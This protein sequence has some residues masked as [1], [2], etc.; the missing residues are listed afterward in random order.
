MATVE[1]SFGIPLLRTGRVVSPNDRYE[2]SEKR[3]LSRAPQLMNFVS[4]SGAAEFVSHRRMRGSPLRKD[5]AY[6]SRNAGFLGPLR[7]APAQASRKK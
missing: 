4:L 2:Q 5:A 1:D 3:S 6:S 7:I